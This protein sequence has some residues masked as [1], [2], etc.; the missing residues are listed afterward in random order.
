MREGF[1]PISEGGNMPTLK[2]TNIIKKTVS[3]TVGVPA[4]LL[5]ISE[6]RNLDFWW[7]PFIGLGTVVAILCWNG[8]FKDEE[9][10][11][12]FITRRQ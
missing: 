5:I 8:I 12:Y 6:I 1:K 2:K 9:Q 4:V 3:W 7:L 10:T 11:N